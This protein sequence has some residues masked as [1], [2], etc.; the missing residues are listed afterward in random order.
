MSIAIRAATSNDPSAILVLEQRTP[1]AAH[2]TAEQYEKLVKAGVLLVAEDAD[3]FRGFIC[4]QAMAGEWEIENVVVASE[5]Q[6]RGVGS[7]LLAELI[8]RARV[9]LASAILLE[10]RES[11]ATA[12]RLYQKFGFREVGRRRLYYIEPIEDA[13]LYELRPVTCPPPESLSHQI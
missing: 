3:V 9:A 2:W 7:H 13:I 10:V 8:R 12:R 6:R 5:S 1:G 11:N 4:A